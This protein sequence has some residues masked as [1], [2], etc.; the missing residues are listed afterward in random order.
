V[1]AITKSPALDLTSPSAWQQPGA[2]GGGLSND[3]DPFGLNRVN[4]PSATSAAN[5]DDGDDDDDLLGDLGRPVAE[6]QRRVQQRPSAS[7]GPGKPIEDDDSSSSS[8]SGNDAPPAP[9]R[10]G[11]DP[12]DQAVVQLMDYGFTAEDARR[13]LTESGAGVNVQA[14][15]NWLLDDAHRKAKEKAKAGRARQDPPGDG[16]PAWMRETG[17]SSGG[18]T[19][20]ERSPGNGA[21]DTADLSR[22]AAAMGNSL[23]KTANSLWKTGQKKVQ[24]AMAEFQE[25]DDPTQPKWMRAAAAQQQQQQQQREGSAGGSRARGGADVTDE[26]MMLEG[27]RER[28]REREEQAVDRPVRETPPRAE[29]DR[30]VFPDHR[31]RKPPVSREQSPV[32]SA[33]SSGRSTPKWQQQQQQ[34]QQQPAPAFDS[35]ARLSKLAKED[36]DLPVYVS[37]NRRR[38]PRPAAEAEGDLLGGGGSGSRP[39]QASAP[40][41]ATPPP[42]AARPQTTSAF[43][44]RPPPA[45][46]TP[47]PAAPKRQIPDLPPSVLAAS[48]R[49]RLAG[50]AHFKRGDYA[51]AHESYTASLSGVPTSHPLAIVLLTNRA[52]THLKTGA[53]K[54]AAQ[55]ADA[56]LAVI[57]PGGGVAETV[58]V[59]GESGVEEARD[60]RDLFGKALSRKAEALEQMERWADASAVWQACVEAGVGGANAVQGR[61][62]CQ[63]ALAPKVR[64]PAVAPRP[65][66][67]RPSNAAASSAAA[68]SSEA[69]TRLRQAN[70]AAAREDDEKFALADQVDARIA[71]WRDG[72]TD[73]LRALLGSL[74]QV[75][76]DGSGWT[77]VGMAD[78]VMANRVKVV[79]MRAI[80]KTHPDKVSGG[81]C[82]PPVIEWQMQRDG[83]G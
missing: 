15:A 78:L 79:Y 66:P 31:P 23:F 74:D 61:Q 57:G 50:T 76:W 72:K 9:A 58:C 70:A 71:A 34:Q 4:Q 39:P 65:A 48:N 20:R 28:R 8:S 32:V 26:A 35:R 24:Q 41:R 75:L 43:A 2:A 63:T 83:V 62:R 22:T 42:Q 44:P 55:D 82:S 45:T 59:V 19:R 18:Q 12:F 52:L 38:T 3:D 54:L 10:A 14:A 51:S 21:L 7:P 36:D 37:A 5:D 40:A 73:N 30:S 13:G 11:D 46:P 17:E 49:H 33:P 16:A 1:P 69:V 67:P 47:R 53:P 81:G 60:M 77:K 80:G 56:A 64:K 29:R 27:G 25:A 68:A 6:V